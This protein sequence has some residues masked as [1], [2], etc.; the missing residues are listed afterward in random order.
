VATNLT[1]ARNFQTELSAG[2]RAVAT[3]VGGGGLKLNVQ[4]NPLADQPTYQ[5]TCQLTNV[6]LPALNNFLR[7]YGKF[8]VERGQFALFA[9]VAAK[10]GSYDGYLKVFFDHLDV[11]EWEKERKKNALQIFWEAIVGTLT[12]VLKNQQKDQLATRIP[13]SGNYT[14]KNIGILSAVGGI[15]RNAFIRALVPRLDEK[16]TVTTVEKK[17]VEKQTRAST[18]AQHEKRGAERLVHPE[19]P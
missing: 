14:E 3:T 8:D 17:T 19:K 5:M 1:N 16:V 13:I 10:D 18:A 11:F 9:S 15:L 12:T 2:I 4:L 7:A 6:D